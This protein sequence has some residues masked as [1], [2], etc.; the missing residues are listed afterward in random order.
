MVY[1]YETPFGNV[2]HMITATGSLVVANSNTTTAT[3]ASA[4]S[5]QS[6]MESPAPMGGSSS[7]QSG[8]NM[9][10]DSAGTMFDM[11]QR[12]FPG[13]LNKAKEIVEA[14]NKNTNA[15]KRNV[16]GQATDVGGQYLKTIR[17]MLG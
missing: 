12:V 14:V 9:F 6:F 3:S 11:M 1:E 4:S 15:P 7:A 13:G 10:G 17:S 2:T 5:F 8:D 16:A